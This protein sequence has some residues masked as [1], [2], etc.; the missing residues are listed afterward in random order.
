MLSGALA[1]QDNNEHIV[2]KTYYD[3]WNVTYVS[4]HLI[5]YQQRTSADGEGAAGITVLYFPPIMIDDGIYG[6]LGILLTKEKKPEYIL[7]LSFP[8]G[9][10]NKSYE[11][12]S[13]NDMNVK[14]LLMSGK[15]SVLKSATSESRQDQI[16]VGGTEFKSRLYRF[17]LEAND[18]EKL[19]TRIPDKMQLYFNSKSTVTKP[20]RLPA[21]GYISSENPKIS[22]FSSFANSLNKV[23]INKLH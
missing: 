14:I 10:G 6:S 11:N 13:N 18:F 8:V 23:K 12:L 3:I 19:K 15:D 16:T 5:E 7:D 17:P 22:K 4:E 1:G 9:I 20:K 21:P 2:T